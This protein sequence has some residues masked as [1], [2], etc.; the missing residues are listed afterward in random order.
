MKRPP[1]PEWARRLKKWAEPFERFVRD[2]TAGLKARDLQRLFEADASNAYKIL[3]RDQSQ[4]EQQKQGFDLFL[5]RVKVV[6]LGLSYKLSPARR[7]LFAAAILFAV[8]G[9]VRFDYSPGR[10]GINLDDSLLWFLCSIVGLVFL[11]GLE[12]VD[13]VRIRDE[14]EI[15]RQ[16]QHDLLPQVPPPIPGYL[17]AFSYRTANEVGGDYYDFIPI[18]DGRFAIISGDASGHGMAAGLLM[19]ITN[20]ALRLAI[21]ID[22]EPEKVVRLVNRLLVHTG[23]KRAF[24][25]LF[26]AVLEPESGRFDYVCAGHPFPFLRRANGEIVELGSGA[27]PLGLRPEIK[28]SPASITIE[29]GDLLLLYSDGLP[30]AVNRETDADYGFDRLRRAFAPGGVPQEVHDRILCDLGAF[31]RAEPPNDDISL[32]VMNRFATPPPPPPPPGP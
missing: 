22:S 5:H 4:P 8:L 26:F 15:A 13:R 28:P 31:L 14:L 21:D 12:L 7:V 20:A 18:G 1:A 19:A 17:F 10:G 23:G 16:L 11:L 6:F 30:E 2:Y 3:V 9:I 24:M 27:L 25:T 29:P 32:V